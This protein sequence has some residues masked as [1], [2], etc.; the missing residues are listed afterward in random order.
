MRAH[1]AYL[2]PV[3]YDDAVGVPDGGK[4]MGDDQAGAVGHDLLEGPLYQELGLG[5]D[6]G[7]GLVQH[8]YLRIDDKHP[9]QRQELP[10]PRRQVASPLA[11]GGPQPAGENAG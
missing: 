3:E 9:H 6:A 4:A 7:G 1:L 2:A 10:L 11:Y 8:Q 5:V